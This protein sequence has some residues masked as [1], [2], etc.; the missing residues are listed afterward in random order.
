MTKTKHIFRKKKLYIK[1]E[2][3]LVTKKKEKTK[4]K[5]NSILTS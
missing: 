3:H 2:Y 4:F 1:L 5:K